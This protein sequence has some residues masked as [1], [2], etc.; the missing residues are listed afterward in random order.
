MKSYF[1]IGVLFIAALQLNG[2]ALGV[3]TPL[4]PEKVKIEFLATGTP[5]ALKIR[6]VPEKNPSV[7]GTWEAANGKGRLEVTAALAAFDTGIA[8]R[9]SHMREKYLE[10]QKYPEAKLT[11]E[12][13]D[14]SQSEGTFEGQLTL[15]GQTGAVRGTIKVAEPG[16]P[17]NLELKFSLQLSNFGIKVPSFMGVSVAERVEV[18]GSLS[19]LSQ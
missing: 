16:N 11:V 19:E 6:G 3:S 9:N 8:L 14:F 1:E 10:V 13:L 12:A 7:K 18:T 17:A 15:H 2:T 4:N 5:S